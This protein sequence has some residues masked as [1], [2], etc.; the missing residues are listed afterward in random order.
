MRLHSLDTVY[1]YHKAST[2]A[3]QTL[4]RTKRHLAADYSGI[5]QWIYS[6]GMCK[7]NLIHKFVYWVESRRDLS[8]E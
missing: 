1:Y 3:T 7:S 5:P 2:I 6:S 4:I 8:V